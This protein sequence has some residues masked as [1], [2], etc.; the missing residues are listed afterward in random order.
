MCEP[1]N[2]SKWEGTKYLKQ[3]KKSEAKREKSTCQ[4]KHKST[5]P[6]AAGKNGAASASDL[7]TAADAQSSKQC[8]LFLCDL[9]PFSS[10]FVC[11]FPPSL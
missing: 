6:F 8:A 3:D 10:S 7:Q 5:P 4:N 11:V 9:Y 1:K 2:K